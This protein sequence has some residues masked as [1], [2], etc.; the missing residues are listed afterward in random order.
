MNRRLAHSLALAL[1][2]GLGLAGAAAAVILEDTINLSYDLAPGGELSLGNDNGNID[3]EGWDRSEV[4]IEAIKKVKAGNRDTAREALERLEVVA[5]RRGNRVEIRVR[6]PRDTSGFLAWVFGNEVE[7]Q[8]NF[9]VRVPRGIRVDVDTANG[10]VAV[11]QVVG[12]VDA[13]S[14]NGGVTIENVSGTVDASTVNGSIRLALPQTARVSLDAQT[15]NGGINLE[16][17]PS[18]VRSKGRRHLSADVNGGGAK[19]ALSTTN[20]GIRISG[21]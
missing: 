1:A 17:L 2:L 4:R 21:G 19:I 16:G 5:E 15:T 7:G 8:V 9:K 20:G 6:R 11:R 12:R 14:V 18:D 13:E 3:V 10:A